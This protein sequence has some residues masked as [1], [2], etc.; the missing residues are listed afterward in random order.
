MSK[1][2]L[3]GVSIGTVCAAIA[4]VFM[5]VFHKSL[6]PEVIALLPVA[7]AAIAHYL[8]INFA[9]N[10]AVKAEETIDNTPP[11]TISETIV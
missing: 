4:A 11:A 3:T 10:K 2:T 8:G 9:L 6:S 1:V 5:I 7:V